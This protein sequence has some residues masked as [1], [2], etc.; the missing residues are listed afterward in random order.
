MFFEELGSRR[1]WEVDFFK[2][3]LERLDEN[4]VFSFDTTNIATD[5]LRQ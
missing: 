3:C 4:E 1:N 2:A 5:V